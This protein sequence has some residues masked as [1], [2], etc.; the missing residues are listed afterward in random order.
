MISEEMKIMTWNAAQAVWR[1]GA[2]ELIRLSEA[3]N[4]D[5]FLSV[6]DLLT[7]CKGRIVTSGCGTS[8]AAAK[9]IA[10]TLSVVE[11]PSFFLSPTDAVH[12][13]LGSV[14]SGDVAIL[15]SKG[16][17][18]HEILSMI[19]ALKTKDVVIVGVT[20]NPESKLA[21]AADYLVHVRVEK[22]ADGFNMLATTST[23]A[24]VAYF[25]ALAIALIDTTGF[26]RKQ[27]ALIHPGGAVGERLLEETIENNLHPGGM[28]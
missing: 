19:P 26:T 18:T 14:Q 24:V 5:V 1:A 17:N 10:H 22:E 11:R 2:G 27:F 23:L 16:G 4:R 21:A 25:D 9:K 28:K 7:A 6:L 3:G 13:A 8:G 15:I 12:G 20:E